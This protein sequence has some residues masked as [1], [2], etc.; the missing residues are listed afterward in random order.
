MKE[1]VTSNEVIDGWRVV[2]IDLCN[3]PIYGLADFPFFMLVNKLIALGAPIIREG[4][5]WLNP[6]E[7][8]YK[9]TGKIVRFNTDK[10]M[11]NTY[12]KWKENEG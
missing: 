12:F 2:G 9:H 11:N 10:D 7:S 6:K 8:D 3:A 5:N 1:F 4:N